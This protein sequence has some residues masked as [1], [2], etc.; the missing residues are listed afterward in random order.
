MGG[1]ATI[2]MSLLLGFSTLWLR[3]RMYEVFLIVHV[4]FAVLIIVGLFYHTA[5]FEG[6]YNGYLW[7]LVGIWLFDRLARVARLAYCNV[8]VSFGSRQLLSE[9]EVRYNKDG[10]MLELKISP[11]AQNMRLDAGQHY[12]IYQSSGWKMWENHPFTLASWTSLRNRVISCERR[13]PATASGLVH[14]A[15]KSV[16]LSSGI[17]SPTQSDNSVVE[18][19]E[20]E[21]L[22]FYVRPYDSWTRRLQASCLKSPTSSISTRMLIEGPYGHR[23]PLHTFQNV[24]F[25]VGGSGITAALPYLQEFIAN[26]NSAECLTRE[27]TFVW[28]LR[29]AAMVHEIMEQNL[30]P[31]LAMDNIK[32]RFHITSQPFAA[33]P[34][35]EKADAVPDRTLSIQYEQERPDI[36]AIVSQVV[37]NVAEAGDWASRVAVF[38]CGP[39]GMA[40][41]ARASVHGALKAHKGRVNVRYFEES[42]GW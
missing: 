42:F 11:S 9:A 40:D 29:Q 36:C 23:A 17:S 33:R 26:Q 20:P 18:A 39:A 27:V 32:C 4:A 2:A 10:H 19:V 12:F 22:V 6:E 25:I 34:Q 41:E 8:R 7:P 3:R 31:L 21:S 35:V 30:R 38:A 37:A 14:L 28:T 15:P 13:M 1:M 5:I 16:E 24:V